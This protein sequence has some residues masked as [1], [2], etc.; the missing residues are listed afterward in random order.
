VQ[1]IRI[2]KDVDKDGELY[3]QNIPCRKGQRVEAILLIDAD[4]A[5]GIESAQADPLMTLCGLG[6]EIWAGVGP[7]R[8]AQ[9]LREGW[10]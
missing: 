3:L 6:K 2:Y 1:A 10:E 9:E 7:D 8:Y 4:L 5:A